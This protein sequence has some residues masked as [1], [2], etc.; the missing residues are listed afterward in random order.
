M[1]LPDL[2]LLKVFS[3]LNIQERFRTLRL[4]CRSWKQLIEYQTKTQKSAIVYDRSRPFHR[5]WPDDRA[6]SSAETMDQSLF[7][8]CLANDHYKRIKK[9]YLYRVSGASLESAG[10]MTQ[11][12]QCMFQLEVLS[13]DRSHLAFYASMRDERN[14]YKI[15]SLHG[16]T[17]PHLRALSVKQGFDGKVRITA[18][19][20]EKLAVC[21]F[22]PNQLFLADTLMLDLSHPERL[23]YLQCDFIKNEEIQKFTNLEHLFAQYVKRDFNLSHCPKL[24]RL[25]LCLRAAIFSNQ[26]ENFLLDSIEDL[27][28]QKKELKLNHLKITNFGL[29]KKREESRNM[30]FYKYASLRN[31]DRLDFGDFYLS[32]LLGKKNCPNFEVE[33]LPWIGELYYPVKLQGHERLA[34]CC[35]M[36]NIQAVYVGLEE[37][38]ITR[39]QPQL[40][41][42]P[43][44][45][46][47]FL[48]E[49]GGIRHLT[50]GK[51][52]SFSQ[53]FYD[54]LSIVP[55][56]TDLKIMENALSPSNFEFI[57]GIK[58]LTSI[59]VYKIR[60]STFESF[61]EN[62]KKS[63]INDFQIGIPTVFKLVIEEK[64]YVLDYS[65]TDNSFSWNSFTFDNMDEAFIYLKQIENVLNEPRL[66][67]LPF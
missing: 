29:L 55:F 17:F 36:L 47:K 38:Y 12:T 63:K 10:L 3:F 28:Q 5:R 37:S 52:D 14:E 20:L 67:I 19:L 66:S 13:I 40:A 22:A 54:Q 64:Q 34:S 53:E 62:V 44:L 27:L 24:K 45:L 51:L 11:L 21:N 9:L 35:H 61:H 46:I 43:A 42:D 8:F 50:I 49:I 57:C 1:N 32:Y 23:R 7:Q 4:V 58:F 18:P 41:P 56:I 59:F 30:W 6:L 2:V 65:N 15:I 26:P 33:Q 48:V 39:S 25:D 16:L 60:T 31:N